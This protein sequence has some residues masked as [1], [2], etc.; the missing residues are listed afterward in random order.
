MTA[1]FLFVWHCFIIINT[2]ECRWVHVDPPFWTEQDC[3][4]EAAFR[5]LTHN[6][7]CVELPLER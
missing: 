4:D 5:N 3:H 7:M 1:W 6:H 2:T